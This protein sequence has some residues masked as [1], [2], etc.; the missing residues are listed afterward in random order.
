MADD[1]I[2]PC[3]TAL[4]LTSSDEGDPDSEEEEWREALKAEVEEVYTIN[5]KRT[6][7]HCAC[8]YRISRGKCGCGSVCTPCWQPLTA[9]PLPSTPL[10]PSLRCHGS[11]GRERRKDTQSQ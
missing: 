1:E 4:Y 8:V 2:L 3:I 7:I 6:M 11:M 10:T 9:S 5:T